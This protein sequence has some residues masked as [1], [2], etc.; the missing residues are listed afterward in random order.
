MKSHVIC[1]YKQYCE[2]LTYKHLLESSLYIILSE[3]NLNQR[4]A[5]LGLNNITAAGLSAISNMTE[6]VKS[7]QLALTIFTNMFTLPFCKNVTKTWHK[8]CSN[9][10]CLQTNQSRFSQYKK[11]F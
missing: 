9:G 4:K 2:S 1:M 7:G 8:H 5:L 6:L 10:P 11:C 3:L